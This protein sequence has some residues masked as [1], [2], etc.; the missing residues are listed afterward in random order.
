MSS[1]LDKIRKTETDGTCS[2]HG[3]H[4]KCTNNFTRYIRAELRILQT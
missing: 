1:S 4:E 3:R 2:T